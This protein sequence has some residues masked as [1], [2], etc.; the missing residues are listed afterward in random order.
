MLRV[1]RLATL[2]C[3]LPI[4]IE[5]A[6]NHRSAE[7][8][9][10]LPSQRARGLV[11]PAAHNEPWFSF[12]AQLHQIGLTMNPSGG[13][14]EFPKRR[15]PR[16]FMEIAMAYYEHVLIAR[17]DVSAQQ[18][19]TLVE[20]LTKIITDMGGKVPKYEYWGVRTLAYR[21]KKNRK[22]HYALL[23]IDA[24]A[25]AVHELE[26]RQRLNEDVLRYMTIAV[27][28]LETGQSAVLSKRGDRDDKRPSRGDRP[29][30]GER[31]DRGERP[32]RGDRPD[33]G[34]RAERERRF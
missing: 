33:R 2:D 21:I 11:G 22:G 10:Q 34:P 13:G 27:D 7:E 4:R 17:Q 29:D 23:N 8:E 26:R 18:V 1:R 25:P 28:E 31:S 5:R 12:R 14:F 30:R 32:D 15:S 3:S 6:E 19:E 20:E 9:T 16:P 24:P